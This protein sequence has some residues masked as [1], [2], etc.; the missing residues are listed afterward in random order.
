[1]FSKICMYLYWAFGFAI[2]ECEVG[3]R[4]VDDAR[5]ARGECGSRWAE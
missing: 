2:S 4:V 3:G 5:G 1:M